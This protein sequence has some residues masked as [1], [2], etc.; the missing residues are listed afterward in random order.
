MAY[1]R[2]GPIPFFGLLI[3][4]VWGTILL[5][6]GTLLTATLA[7]ILTCSLGMMAMTARMIIMD[8][9]M[10]IRVLVD[11]ELM[12]EV[13]ITAT[14]VQGVVAGENVVIGMPVNLNIQNNAVV[15]YG[16]EMILGRALVG[17]DLQQLRAAGVA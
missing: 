16:Q 5:N 1:Y 8:G 4:T 9:W 17:Y 7:G 6:G 13:E 14:T 10:E 3:M 15:M 2:C 12:N 11:N